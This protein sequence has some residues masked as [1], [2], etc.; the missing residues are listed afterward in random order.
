METVIISIEQVIILVKSGVSQHRVLCLLME[1]SMP[2]STTAGGDLPLFSR[3]SL[4]C[5]TS[6]IE[7]VGRARCFA[8]SRGFCRAAPTVDR[9]S[10]WSGAKVPV[11]SLISASLTP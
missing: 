7:T 9:R 1:K 4:R 6:Y 3:V 8:K 2:D 10:I 11:V 5:L